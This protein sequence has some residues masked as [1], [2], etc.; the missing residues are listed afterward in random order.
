MDN[1]DL[2]AATF[3]VMNT[4]KR[5]SLSAAELTGGMMM[6]PA[7]KIPQATAWMKTWKKLRRRATL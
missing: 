1:V 5:N 4:P 3:L 2:E 7:R 6:C